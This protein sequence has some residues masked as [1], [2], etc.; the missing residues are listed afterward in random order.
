MNKLLV[1][2]IGL[3]IFFNQNACTSQATSAEVN[4]SSIQEAVIT[5]NIGTEEFNGYMKDKSQAIILDVR[6]PGEVTEGYLEGALNID[7]SNKEFQNNLQKLDKS[8]PVLVYCR[9]G[10]RSGIAMNYMRDMGF[11][12]VYNLSGGIIAWTQAGLA[13]TK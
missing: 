8:K 11:V 3:I 7:F 4:D 13:I 10:R 5:K 9:S 2:L 12:E 1:I 6:T